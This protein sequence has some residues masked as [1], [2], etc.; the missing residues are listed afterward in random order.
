MPEVAREEFLTDVEYDEQA[1]SL[2]WR[3]G[4]L[5]ANMDQAEYIDGGIAARWIVAACHTAAALVRCADCRFWIRVQ[6]NE[7]DCTAHRVAIVSKGDCY[8]SWGREKDA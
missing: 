6:G 1:G 8:C 3:E 2:L 4:W 7:G 5:D